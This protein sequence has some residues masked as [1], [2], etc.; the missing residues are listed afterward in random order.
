MRRFI[1]LL[2]LLSTGTALG[3]TGTVKDNLSLTSAIL[4]GDRNY[5]VYLPPGY[6]SS[7]RSYPVLYLLHGAG[8]DH[9]GWVQFGEV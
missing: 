6:D 2:F 4:Q 3:Q 9:S 5:A 7:A 1:L 8:D